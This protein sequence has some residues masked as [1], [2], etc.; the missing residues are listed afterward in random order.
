MVDKRVVA[1]IVSCLLTTTG[2]TATP[3]PSLMATPPQPMWTEL[4]VQQKIVL[5]PLS[6]D[7]DSLENYR[8]KKWLAIAARFTKVTAEEQ[9][10]IQGQM[11]L[12]GKLTPEERQ[13]VREKFKTTSRLPIEKKNE[14]KQKWEEYQN[15]PEEQK[16]KL[17][18]EVASKS[19]AK[20]RRPATVSPA[21]VLPPL[22]PLDIPAASA[23]PVPTDLQHAIQT[24][25]SGAPAASGE[26][27]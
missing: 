9:Y 1:V 23:Q 4:T 16:A 11:Q 27:H 7:W 14:L 12:W 25:E 5:A 24:N 3:S 17:Q 2:W 15:L 8:Q 18:Q 6:D 26:P 22:P 13:Q 21:A 19:V 20:P 10:R